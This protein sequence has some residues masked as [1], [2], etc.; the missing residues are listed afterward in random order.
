MN[1]SSEI[2][3]VP[4]PTSKRFV[5]LTGRKFERWTVLSY[6]GKRGKHTYWNCLCVC[7]SIESVYSSNLTRGLTLSCGCLCKE[8]TGDANRTHGLTRAPE[9]KTWAGMKRR[10]LNKRDVNYPNYG[11]RGITICENWLKSFET[12]FSDMGPKPSSDH[13]IERRSND[14]G[15]EPDNCFWAT[16]VQQA[17]NKRTN[18]IVT[19]RGFTGTLAQVSR[20]FGIHW[21]SIR[22]WAIR[23][24]Q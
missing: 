5:D 11:G 6:A 17:N 21:S 1:E 12:F 22:R 2:V 20:E 8:R 15:Y 19:F 23:N 13:S 16:V 10:C 14:I 7:G 3:V 9:Y 18:H 24:G 4:L